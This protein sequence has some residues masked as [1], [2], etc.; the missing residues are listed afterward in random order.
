MASTTGASGT[1]TDGSGGS[2]GDTS[3]GGTGGTGSTDTGPVCLLGDPAEVP[4]GPD[5]GVWVR[6]SQPGD[7]NNPGTQA[8]PVQTIAKAVE[9]ALAGP[10]YIY[11]CGEVFQEA[12]SLPAG[13]FLFG[14]FDCAGNGEWHYVGTG[15]RA[16]VAPM[17]HD[18]IAFTFLDGDDPSIAGDLKIESADALNPGGSSIAVFFRDTSKATLKRSDVTAGNGAN[19]ADG[20]PGDY[21]GV[22]APQGL[23]G[24]NGSDACVSNPGV[25]GDSVVQICPDGTV[26]KS[27]YGG[28]GDDMIANDGAEGELAPSPNPSGYGLGG[29]G[30]SAAVGMACSA[31][32]GGAQGADGKDGLGAAPGG[33]DY[34]RLTADGAIIGAA[35][36]DGGAGTP[37][38]GGGGGG[39]SLGKALCGAAPPG[40]AGGG[41]GGTGGCGGKGGKGGQAGG[42]SIG[43]ATRAPG[44]RLIGVSIHAGNGGKG[45][46]GGVLQLGGQP[47]LPGLGGAG[48]VN[49]IKAACA[50]GAGGA[51]GKGGNGGGGRGGHSIALAYT[52]VDAP[53]VL[54][55]GTPAEGLA[56]KGGVGGNPAFFDGRGDHGVSVPLLLFSK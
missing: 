10:K 40:G 48:M 6:V 29:K 8:K 4:V 35:G 22:P 37:G 5:C 33:G 54:D 56:G 47:G 17:V 31:G 9:L 36:E 2:G 12:V 24:L 15:K 50:G 7:D 39:G 14:G 30:E 21:K 23:S 16:T 18:V 3:S 13:V 38:Q 53:P 19:G 25:G 52:A 46:N 28:N 43:V 34:G 27:G 1:G 41:S 49:G 26:S 55:P 44:T 20:D 45:G 11:A 42:S 32:I 51:G